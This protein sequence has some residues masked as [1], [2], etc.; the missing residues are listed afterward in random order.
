MQRVHNKYLH[1]ELECSWS[2][3][4]FILKK[5]LK[6]ESHAKPPRLWV[7]ELQKTVPK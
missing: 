2:M 7:N 1:D 3:R 6:C 5:C 4:Y